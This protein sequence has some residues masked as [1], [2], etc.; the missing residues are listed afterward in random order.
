MTVTRTKIPV[1]AHLLSVIVSSRSGARFFVAA[2]AVLSSGAM[3]R[4]E[5]VVGQALP[6]TAAEF[7]ARVEKT[8]P[9]FEA[10]DA[11]VAA[12]AAAVTAAGLWA[13]PSVAYD[14]E[15]IFTRAG[16]SP[17]NIVRLE[18]PLEISGRRGLE[19]ESAELG[20]DA[21]RQT[22]ARGKQDILLDALE[23]YLRSAASRLELEALVQERAALGRLVD[24]IK[25]R[26]AAGDTSGHD[27]DRLA[28]EADALGDLIEDA[29]R[30][31]MAYRRA[32][33]LLAG[34]P[35]SLLDATD[36]LDLPEIPG[37]AQATSLLVDRP[38]YQAARLRVAQAEKELAA[39]GRGWIPALGL[40]AGAKSAGVETDADWG[41][42]AGLAFSLPF[43]DHGQAD[44][45][46]ARAHLQAARAELQLIE[47]RARVQADTSR[48][49]LA[50]SVKQAQRYEQIQLPR[51]D[52]LVKRAE[53]SYQEGEHHVFE[54]LDAY[55][56]A[57]ETRLRAI[58]LRLLARLAEAETW[59]SLGVGPG[60]KT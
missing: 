50:R 29:E 21:A 11:D 40:S 23:L 18:L 45:E 31:L 4:A 6:L 37:G 43:L 38:D 28:L 58:E 33:G 32:L 27:L 25:A 3:A 57:R 60:G 15:E 44:A 54:L 16:R 30:E 56:T 42:V 19:V 53:T 52:R 55:R 35:G 10:L 1:F 49:S 36:A 39:A 59:R 24:A 8:D 12:Q 13:N 20:V 51:L 2:L 47:Q 7:L 34:T 9:R 22:A 17:E 26:T 48:D 14:R 5:G 46:L 41:Y